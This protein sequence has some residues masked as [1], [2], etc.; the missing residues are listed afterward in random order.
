MLVYM[1]CTLP[2]PC[3][4]HTPVAPTR[5]LCLLPAL[6]DGRLDGAVL[7]GIT[8]GSGRDEKSAGKAEAQCMGAILHELLAGEAAD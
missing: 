1:A 5:A 7:D 8:A 3:H 4:A 6:R 2:I